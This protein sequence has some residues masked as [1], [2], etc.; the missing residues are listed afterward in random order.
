MFGQWALGTSPLGEPEE[1]VTTVPMP[2][3][4]TVWIVSDE[5]TEATPITASIVD[6]EAF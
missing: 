1:L 5:S 2:M 6:Q 4:C 3:V